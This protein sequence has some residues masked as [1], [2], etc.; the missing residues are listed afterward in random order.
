MGGLGEGR[1]GGGFVGGVPDVHK[2]LAHKSLVTFYCVISHERAKETQ[3][4]CLLLNYKS[5]MGR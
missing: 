2:L 3:M 1:G 5:L 4:R